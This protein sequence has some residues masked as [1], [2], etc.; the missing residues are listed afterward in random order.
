LQL[1]IVIS[2][3]RFNPRIHSNVFAHGSELAVFN[4]GN[5]GT[6][7]PQLRLTL[8]DLGVQ[9]TVIVLLNGERDR[10]AEHDPKGESTNQRSPKCE[11]SSQRP[12]ALVWPLD[13][14]PTPTGRPRYL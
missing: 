14:L 1:L 4:S 2:E 6:Q 13:S 5:L 8:R 9:Y 3:K 10:N 11:I 12:L 7:S